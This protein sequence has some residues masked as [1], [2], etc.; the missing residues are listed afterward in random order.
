MGIYGDLSKLAGTAETEA[1]V[2][3]VGAP[4]PSRSA[5][6]LRP[7]RAERVRP[8]VVGDA[9]TSVLHGVDLRA[10]RDGIVNTETHNSALRMTV[11]EREQ[12]ED[13]IRD[14]K[15]GERIRTSMN[16]LAR[17]GLMFL[18]HDYRKE[19]KKSVVC[20]VKSA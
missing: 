16:E 18:I 14:L 3:A 10:W 19:G 11:A 7:A 4:P 12:V 1:G 6:L 2:A 9:V 13:L 5:A 20:V 8:D 17:L 15:R